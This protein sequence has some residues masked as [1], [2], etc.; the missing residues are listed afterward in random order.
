[1]HQHWNV[2]FQF[3]RV[4]Q[5]QCVN[6][7]YCRGVLASTCCGTAFDVVEP[8]A[9]ASLAESQFGGCEHGRQGVSCHWNWLWEVLVNDVKLSLR[10]SAC[11]QSILYSFGW[12]HMS[13]PMSQKS[14]L[15]KIRTEECCLP[16]C[17]RKCLRNTLLDGTWLGKQMDL[18]S[19]AGPISPPT[20]NKNMQ[21][22]PCQLQKCASHSLQVF[23]PHLHGSNDVRNLPPSGQAK[24][25]WMKIS[26]T[27]NCIGPFV[28]Q[29]TS[30]VGE[31]GPWRI[32][33]PAL[34]LKQHSV[35][36]QVLLSLTKEIVDH[37]IGAKPLFFF[38]WGRFVTW[39]ENDWR[40]PASGQLSFDF[41][42]LYRRFSMDRCCGGQIGG[43]W[44]Q[45][46]NRM[47]S[48]RK[49][50]WELR[51]RFCKGIWCSPRLRK[52][53]DYQSINQVER[54]CSKRSPIYWLIVMRNLRLTPN[55]SPF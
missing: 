48:C 18:C 9:V 38:S 53:S 50:Q 37:F 24:D 8:L 4:S 29:H 45:I 16:L 25:L 43:I 31:D 17:L 27:P 33:W 52:T 54:R 28:F 20:C 1:M 19:G 49:T 2:I 42:A 41:V 21:Q 47:G 23:T 14:K 10:L 6:C 13:G 5:G 22:N 46:T 34:L 36:V 39:A 30:S 3:S 11:T 51:V 12:S 26:W 40:L 7:C 35:R 15:R 32:F 55:A 44:R